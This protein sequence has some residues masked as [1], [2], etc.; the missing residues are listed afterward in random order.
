[1][2]DSP[3]FHIFAYCHLIL[4]M[5]PMGLFDFFKRGRG[6]EV[7]SLKFCEV[8]KTGRRESMPENRL[9]NNARYV[10]PVARIVSHVDRK[11]KMTMR[12]AAPDGK[13]YAYDFEVALSPYGDR[14]VDLPRWGSEGRD[15]F[16]TPGIWKFGLFDEKDKLLVETS[17][18]VVPAEELW[19]EQG[20]IRVESDFQFCDD[21][22]EGEAPDDWGR[23]CFVEPRY[24]AMRCRYASLSGVEREV[25][26][27]VEITHESAG[28][29][30]R[31]EHTV[32]LDPRGGWLQMCGWGSDSGTSYLPGRYTYMLCYDGRQIGSGSFEVAKSPRQ[33]GWIEPLALVLYFYNS[34]EEMKHWAAFDCGMG[35]LD[36]GVA[37]QLPFAQGYKYLV[38][39]FQWRSL[40]GGHSL[41]LTFKFYLD[42]KFVYSC[43]R[44]Q[45]TH[46]LD[47]QGLF[48]EDFEISG[49]LRHEGSNGVDRPL[50]AGRYKVELY[51]ETDEL[52]EHFVMQRV[53]DVK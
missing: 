38:A 53:L 5:I 24:I 33:R 50:P 37:K 15:R 42:G 10:M 19:E 14:L 4:V 22:G 9:Y 12:I 8:G 3:I 49:V 32:T 43:A 11:V 46:E 13:Q 52:H 17:L 40:E 7:R 45:M 6:Y 16:T 31:F 51:L 25:A 35:L 18:I 20:W 1:M 28:R 30:G 41:K 27:T 36:G 21:G 39:G 44:E 29:V 34:D 23:T 48:Y 47:P 2:A 26:Y